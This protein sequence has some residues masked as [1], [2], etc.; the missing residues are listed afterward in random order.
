M[1]RR[2]GEK[3][4]HDPTSAAT[5]PDRVP[6]KALPPLSSMDRMAHGEHLGQCPTCGGHQWWDN[7]ARKS[8]GELSRAQPDYVC[9]DCRHGRWIDGRQRS[10]WAVPTGHRTPSVRVTVVAPVVET[11]HGVH[12]G[13][14]CAALKRDGSPCRNVAMAG[15]TYCGPHSHGGAVERVPNRCRGTTKAGTPCR[16][17]AVRGAQYCPQHE[18]R[19]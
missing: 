8:M 3:W 17:G 18:P 6:S 9:T 16:A 15:S 10:G 14:N 12:R 19:P 5:Q 1:P 4:R 13:G 7:R 11:G 2:P